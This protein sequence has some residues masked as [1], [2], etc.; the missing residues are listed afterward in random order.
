[1][2]DAE[3]IVIGSGPGGAISAAL[4]AEAGREVLVLE[5]GPQLALDSCTPFSQAEMVQKYRNAGATVA[6][7]EPRLAYVEARCVGGGSEVNSALYHRA[8]AQA[9]ETWRQDY[10]VRELDGLDRDFAEIESTLG[11]GYLPHPAPASS[12][13]L[14]RGA[15]GLGWQAIEVPRWYRYADGRPPR[16]QSMSETFVQRALKAGAR[17][18]A[19][20]RA[21]ALHRRGE[22]W[23]VQTEEGQALRA[24][25]VFVCAGAIHS[26]ALLRRCG[27]GLAGAA[28]RMHPS[29]KVTALF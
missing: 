27:I 21:T 1:M 23:Q 16:K 25:A 20:C 4:L 13:R 26:A 9:L 15:E 18:R 24:R 22:N 5:E 7:G 6:L 28:L 11:V 12:A 8:P 17:L 19:G 3:V 2:H 29:I 14:K 10:D